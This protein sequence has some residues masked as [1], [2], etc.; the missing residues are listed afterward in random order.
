MHSRTS[1]YAPPFLQSTPLFNRKPTSA[2]AEEC[3]ACLEEE[4]TVRRSVPHSLMAGVADIVERE[5]QG[6]G[7]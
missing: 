3:S 5:G 7:R 4:V 1:T 6:C 2:G